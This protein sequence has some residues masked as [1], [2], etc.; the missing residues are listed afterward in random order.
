MPPN[1]ITLQ[2]L[3]PP[4]GFNPIEARDAYFANSIQ[5][6]PPPDILLDYMYGAAAYQRWGAKDSIG[7]LMQERFSEYFEPV[8]LPLRSPSSSDDSNGSDMSTGMLQA[9]DDI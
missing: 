7:G 6:S 8:T 4:V 5:I 1:R 3:V 9:M 2:H